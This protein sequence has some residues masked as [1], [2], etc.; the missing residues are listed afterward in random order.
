MQDGIQIP[1]DFQ[2]DGD[3]MVGTSEKIRIPKHAADLRLRLLNIAHAGEAGHCG[4]QTPI[5]A[6]KTDFAWTLMS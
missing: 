5:E 6:L 3:G 1:I 2:E 4:F